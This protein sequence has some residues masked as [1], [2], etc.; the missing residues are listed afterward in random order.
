M[1]VAVLDGRPTTAPRPRRASDP[2]VRRYE[3]GELFE[4]FQRDRDPA[5][6]DELVARHRALALHLSRRYR[7]PGEREDLDQIACV[8]LIRAID[9][10]DPA[11]GVAFS[12]FA[13]PTIAGELKRYFRDHGW[14]VRV[15]RSLQELAQRLT[16]AGEQLTRELNRTPTPAELAERC[17]TTVELVLEA[18]LLASAHRADSLDLPPDDDGA[19]ITTDLAVQHVER[20]YDEVENAADVDALLAC[21]SPRDREIVTM[22]FRLDMTQREIADRVGLSQMH[23]SR[24]LRSSL[25][26]LRELADPDGQSGARPTHPNGAAA[27][28]AMNAWSMATGPR[29]S[30]SSVRSPSRS[31]NASRASMPPASIDAS[32]RRSMTTRS[33]SK[34]AV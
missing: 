6:R 19:H 29:T 25:E 7:A 18:R 22:R 16:N 3:T 21:L 33:G 10:F 4:R 1:M 24:V 30:S 32:A 2:R 20:G 13:V 9:R 27:P 28:A 26:H 14:S 17:E 5:V 8:A 11:R 34:W 12:S 31:R 23:V 15:P